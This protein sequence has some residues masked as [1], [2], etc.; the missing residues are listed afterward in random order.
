MTEKDLYAVLGV[1]RTASTD[2]IKRAYRKLARKYHPDLNP[3]KR[4]A[5]ERFKA[6]SEAHDILSDAEKRKLY[7]EF[8]MAGVQAGFDAQKARAYRGSAQGWQWASQ[9][10]TEG[11]TGFGGYSTFEDLFGDIFGR[12]QQQAGG[13]RPGADYEHELEIVLLDAVRGLST[14]INLERPETCGSCSGS[15]AHPTSGVQCL[16]CGG[17]GRV[18]VAKGPLTFTRTCQRCGGSGRS[19]V[20]PCGSC[21]GTGTIR[22][23][24]RLN[25]RIPPGVDND[26]RVRVA[27]KGAAGIGGGP[28]GDLFIRVRV[29]PHPLLERRGDDL[30]MELPVTVAEAMLGASVNVPTFDG[31]VRVRIPPGSQSG[32]QLRVKGRGVPHLK[33]GRR[34]DLYLRL[35]VKL[36]DRD[37]EEIREASRRMEAGYGRN[38]REGLRL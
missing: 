32:T 19:G 22:K 18:Q 3:G 20:R 14:T 36:P 30:Y 10:G 2:E 35:A 37:S 15:G 1:S 28:P 23:S 26:S 5:E 27:G 17:R 24:E 34:G 9:G 6:V 29:R 31:P 16:E 4:D 25:V 11:W 21:S 38:P 13:S 7:D 12:A 33:G 8:G